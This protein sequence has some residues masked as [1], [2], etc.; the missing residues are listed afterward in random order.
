M[1]RLRRKNAMMPSQNG[2]HECE[3]ERQA[4]RTTA[5]IKPN[6]AGDLQTANFPQREPEQRLKNLA[7]VERINRQHIENEQDQI[8]APDHAR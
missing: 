6:H 4:A 7:S 1:A 2:L 8:D 5:P 3:Q